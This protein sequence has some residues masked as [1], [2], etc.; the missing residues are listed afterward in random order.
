MFFKEPQRALHA[1]LPQLTRPNKESAALPTTAR[2][3]MEISCQVGTVGKHPT[4]VA[5]PVV[6]RDPHRGDVVLVSLHIVIKKNVKKKIYTRYYTYI[7][8]E[9]FFQW[10]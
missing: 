2:P 10:Y 3:R 6:P 9:P 1:L 7:D 5:A 8:V 4:M